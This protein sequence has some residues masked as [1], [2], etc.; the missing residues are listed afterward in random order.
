MCENLTVG[1]CGCPGHPLL[2]WPSWGEQGALPY[3]NAGDLGMWGTELLKGSQTYCIT[4]GLSPAQL[5]C[6]AAS[7]VLL[8][9]WHGVSLRLD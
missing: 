2:S 1:S 8:P 7:P 3:P 5:T 4:D 6:S 9:L